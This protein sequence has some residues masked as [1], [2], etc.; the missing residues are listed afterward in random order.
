MKPVRFQIVFGILVLF[1]S[2]EV[3]A[4]SL[5]F[6]TARL[7]ESHDP[8][9]LEGD[10]FNFIRTDYYRLDFEGENV[11]AFSCNGA[12]R[13]TG[14]A[15]NYEYEAVDDDL[16]RCEETAR[17]IE[18][19]VNAEI[20]QRGG[21]AA[22]EIVLN[23]PLARV[24]RFARGIPVVRSA[25]RVVRRTAFRVIRSTARR[26]D[27]LTPRGREVIRRIRRDSERLTEAADVFTQAQQ[28]VESDIGNTVDRVQQAW[29]LIQVKNYLNS[30]SEDIRVYPLESVGGFE[31]DL[32]KLVSDM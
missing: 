5:L 30:D 32:L 4:K 21:M 22:L 13:R 20:A 25:E 8:S 10:D 6:V 18:A 19:D 24:V 28:F 7:F 23:S 16:L 27:R 1:L 11:Y 2:V 12:L 26:I 17:F 9:D 15:P 29:I 14:S 31:E 3:S